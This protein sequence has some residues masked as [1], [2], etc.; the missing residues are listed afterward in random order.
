MTKEIVLPEGWKVDK[1]ENGKIILKEVEEYYPKSWEECFHIVKFKEHID[2][3]MNVISESSRRELPIIACQ[4]SLPA[5]EGVGMGALCKL[6]ICRDAYRNGWTPDWS[7]DNM[8]YTIVNS[9]NRAIV[10]AAIHTSY[11]L[12]FQSKKVRDEFMNNFSSL[13][14]AAK[15]LI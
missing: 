12:S 2:K 4:D 1:I 14:E 11:V 6:L 7:D 9:Y 3:D 13:I 5:R 8:K 15:N 10:G